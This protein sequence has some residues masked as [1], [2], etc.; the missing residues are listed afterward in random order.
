MK[1]LFFSHKFYPDV[2][3]IE[4]I[5]EMLATYFVDN[6]HKVHIVT[7]SK[8]IDDKLFPYKVVRNPDII[9]LLKEFSWADIIIENNICLRLSWLNIIF[10]KPSIVGL[11]TWLSA[12]DGPVKFHDKVKM[13][14]LRKANYVIACSSSIRAVTFPKAILIGNPYDN[15]KF[16]IVPRVSRNKDFV[17][18]GRLVSDKGVDIAIDAFDAF[19]RRN[20]LNK[21]SQLTIIGEGDRRIA[22]EEQ[23]KKYGIEDNIIFTGGMR[24]DALVNLLNQ[25]RYMLVPSLWDEPFGIVA[26][27][28]MACGCV[29]IV[30]G[31]GGLPDAVGKAGLICE[32][33]SV[34]SLIACMI[35]L[36]ENPVLEEQLR[37]ASKEHLIAYHSEA[38]GTSYLNIINTL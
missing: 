8:A 33:G 38:V 9:Q 3:G 20:D 29:P 11:Q 27:E 6:Q 4:S 15:K 21:N 19:L 36:K 30:S 22:L 26:L 1:I 14:W 2:G 35:S 7:T 31:G 12:K 37:E 25:H 10:K 23:V 17:F 13:Y 5:S 32:R 18:L 34:E 16:K 28:G 24:G